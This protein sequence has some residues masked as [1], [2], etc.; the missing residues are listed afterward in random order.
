LQYLDYSTAAFPTVY[1]AYQ[2]YASGPELKKG[3]L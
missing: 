2:K 1:P 3:G